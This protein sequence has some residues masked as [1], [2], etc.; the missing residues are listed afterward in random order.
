MASWSWNWWA[1]E[2]ETDAPADP[3]A[4]EWQADAADEDAPAE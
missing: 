1:H 4:K 2:D 3:A